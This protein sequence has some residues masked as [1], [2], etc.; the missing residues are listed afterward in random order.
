M[1]TVTDPGNSS[2]P[3]SCNLFPLWISKEVRFMHPDCL[4]WNPRE[5]SRQGAVQALETQAS[6]Q[7]HVFGVSIAARRNSARGWPGACTKN[8]H[9]HD[10]VHIL[11]TEL[12]PCTAL[13]PGQ[14]GGPA[15]RA[16]QKV[17]RGEVCN[18]LSHPKE[19]QNS[20]ILLLAEFWT[21]TELKLG[22]H[23]FR[24]SSVWSSLKHTS[25][26]QQK[27]NFCT[28]YSPLQAPWPG[29]GL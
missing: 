26:Q 12:S 25:Q 19:N 23:T 15:E 16:G 7:Q 4:E 21:V 13:P 10:W 17:R 8:G 6:A 11:C 14:R 5:G 9:A 20:F 18:E 1:A 2:F 3:K 22:S 29:Q 28:V 24:S 27:V